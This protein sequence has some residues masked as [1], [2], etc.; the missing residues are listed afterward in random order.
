[1]TRTAN[2]KLTKLDD[3][4]QAWHAAIAEVGA[5]NLS[6]TERR[7]AT[8][9]VDSARSDYFHAREQALRAAFPKSN[10]LPRQTPSDVRRHV[11]DEA[12]VAQALAVWAAAIT[13]LQDPL[14]IGDERAQTL[15]RV[16]EARR[17]YQ[18][19]HRKAVGVWPR[20]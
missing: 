18:V 9:R 11:H 14:L 16:E 4:L 2:P 3:H 19:A 6:A 5:A 17:A 1:L 7:D 10:D 12:T 15:T 13:E 20:V 8:S